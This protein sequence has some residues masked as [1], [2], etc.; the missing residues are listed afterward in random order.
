MSTLEII[1]SSQLRCQRNVDR[2]KAYL[3]DLRGELGVDSKTFDDI[4]SAM[5]DMNFWIE[6][7]IWWDK[8]YQEEIHNENSNQEIKELAA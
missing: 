3:E 5:Q 7:K 2:L 4:Y 8:H 6:Q 1:K